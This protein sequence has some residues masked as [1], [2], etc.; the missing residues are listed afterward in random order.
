MTFLPSSPDASLNQV[1]KAHRGLSQPLSV[2]IEAVMR[3]PSTLGEGERELI[4]AYI[5]AVNG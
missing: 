2:F 5:S 3:G 4:G 1:F